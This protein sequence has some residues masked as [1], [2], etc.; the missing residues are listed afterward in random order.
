MLQGYLAM[1]NI[2]NFVMDTNMSNGIIS[3]V[4][5]QSWQALAPNSSNFVTV[6]YTVELTS[7]VEPE[8]FY[9]MI[10]GK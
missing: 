1:D 8:P 7:E 3:A 9:V 10:N 2:F 6:G 5:N 4:A